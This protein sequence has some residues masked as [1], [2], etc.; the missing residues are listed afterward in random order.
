MDPVYVLCILQYIHTKQYISKFNL[1]CSPQI[2]SLPVKK[3]GDRETDFSSSPCSDLLSCRSD[4][5]L[6]EGSSNPQ[7]EHPSRCSVGGVQVFGLVL[8]EMQP[9]PSGKKLHCS[10]SGQE[11]PKLRIKPSQ[12]CL[13]LSQKD[14]QGLCTSPPSHLGAYTMHT[15]MRMST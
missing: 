12:P 15:K 3:R 13:D 7:Q 10:S 5:H 6:Q 4:L 11:M 8:T 2:C 14:L 9:C 1:F